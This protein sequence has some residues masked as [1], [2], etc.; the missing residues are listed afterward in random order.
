MLSPAN[1]HAPS[2]AFWLANTTELL[3]FLESDKHVHSYATEARAI[4]TQGVRASFQQLV[5]LLEQELGLVIPHMMAEDATSDTKS[6]AG[7]SLESSTMIFTDDILCPRDH[8]GAE[9][10]NVAV[11]AKQ[12]QREPHHPDLLAP[13][14]PRQQGGLQHDPA[15][16]EVLCRHHV[17]LPPAEQV[18]TVTTHQL[19]LSH[20]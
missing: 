5:R 4:L 20:V 16:A 8:L 13:L 10:G 14:P 19:T 3:H 6:C 7:Q 2:L 9:L 1:T 12:A 15:P 11:E 18:M 17:G